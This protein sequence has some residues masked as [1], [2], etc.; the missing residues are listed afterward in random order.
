MSKIYIRYRKPFTSEVKYHEVEIL[1]DLGDGFYLIR[2]KE[3][4]EF[5]ATK[6]MLIFK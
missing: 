5:K 6:G 1:E 3:N 4:G 2:T